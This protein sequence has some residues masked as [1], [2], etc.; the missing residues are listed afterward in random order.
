MDTVEEG[1][2][3]VRTHAQTQEQL[4]SL[5]FCLRVACMVMHS[6]NLLATTH[7]HGHF[8]SQISHLFSNCD[9]AAGNLWY[10]IDN[11]DFIN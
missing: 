1:L 2:G 4:K 3:A 6:T 5:L 7:L 8:A 9:F 11:N 10:L